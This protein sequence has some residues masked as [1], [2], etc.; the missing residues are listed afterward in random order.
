M[1]RNILVTILPVIFLPTLGYASCKVPNFYGF[2]HSD[3]RVE[4]PIFYDD[5]K[6][7]FSFGFN[8]ANAK[9]TLY[10]YDLGLQSI[11]ED[12]WKEQLR[13]SVLDIFNFSKKME[14][15]TKLSDPKLI[16]KK[17]FSH[18]KHLIK[19]AAF[20]VV[21]KGSKSVITIVSLG[22][23]NNCFQK[24]R[25]TQTISSTDGSKIDESKIIDGLLA[26]SHISNRIYFHLVQS[27]YYE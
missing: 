1:I 10:F 11:G 22:S 15:E 26:F 2:S 25:F 16:S 23:D 24:I 27:K 19:G 7:G 17:T 18:V 14:P 4:K 6:L 9:A 8:S 3:W 5:E 13:R 12:Y 20:I 21:S